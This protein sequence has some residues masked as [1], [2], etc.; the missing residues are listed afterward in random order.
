LF[1]VSRLLS[2]WEARG[3]VRLGRE[4]V[5]IADVPSF[6]FSADES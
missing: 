3:I 2:G 6:D 1:T 4:A 5:T